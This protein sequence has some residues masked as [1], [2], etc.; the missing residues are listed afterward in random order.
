MG[1][2]ITFAKALS[3]QAFTLVSN[4]EMADNIDNQISDSIG[5]NIPAAMQYFL[6]QSSK[7]IKLNRSETIF[8]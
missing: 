5:G 8:P 4:W 3:K 7:S 2:D 1:S 6:L